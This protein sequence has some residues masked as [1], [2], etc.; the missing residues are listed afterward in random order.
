M[1]NNFRFIIKTSTLYGILAASFSLIGL[2][3]PWAIVVGDPL[4]TG[5]ITVEHI[6]GHV[7]W[8]ILE[9]KY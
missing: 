7:V 5:G 2:F 8:G 3:L 9:N 1:N 6:A 4:E